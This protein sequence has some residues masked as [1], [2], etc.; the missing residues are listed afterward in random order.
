M[1][2]RSGLIEE[3]EDFQQRGFNRELFWEIEG[4]RGCDKSYF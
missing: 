1:V 2:I 3:E 4:M